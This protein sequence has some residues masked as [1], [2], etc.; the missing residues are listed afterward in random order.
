MRARRSAHTPRPSTGRRRRRR[1]AASESLTR[2]SAARY[3][4]PRMRLARLCVP[5]AALC[6]TAPACKKNVPPH[7]VGLALDVGGRGDQSFN[8]G[9]LRGLEA[10]A[11][12]LRYT[13]RGYEPLPDAEYE[14]LVRGTAF[15]HLGIPRPIVL[16]GKAQE[17]YDPNLRLLVDR[18]AELVVAVG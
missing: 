3:S 16:Q 17:D 12:G 9:A 7:T 5:L 18:G 2:P 4:R 14:K 11:A 6:C 15:P 1:R 13:P 8:D 10:M